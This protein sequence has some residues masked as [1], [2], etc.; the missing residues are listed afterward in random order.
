VKKTIVL[1]VVTGLLVAAAT[2]CAGAIPTTTP[3]T[4]A[5]VDAAVAATGTA[6][7][8]VQATIDAA[9]EAT[10]AVQAGVQAT[11]AAAAE[12]TVVA[13]PTPTPSAEYVTMTEEQ[14]AALID[15]TVV[16]A[17]AST[18]Q[19]S[20]ATAEATVDDV[21]TQ[22]EVDA[23][24]VYAAE[25]EEAIAYAEELIAAYDSL[26][27]ELATETLVLLQAIEEDLTV[28]AE[29]IA[30]ANALLQEIDAALQQ[31][32]TLAEGTLAQ[33][34]TAAQAAGAEA[35]ELQ[36]RNQSV[37]QELQAELENRV[38]TALAVHPDA[39]AGDRQ[40]ALQSALGYLD[41]VRQSLDDARISQ[42]E[43]ADIAQL[44]ANASASLSTQGGPRLQNL[45]G[46]I[47]EI[48]EQIARG[49]IPQAKANLGNL[50]VSLR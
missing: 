1:I 37:L 22:E 12:S 13:A 16:E 42:A 46:S 7:A 14:L 15:E 2:A 34:E 43:L 45:S 11:A 4:Q 23:I 17:T 47:D 36:A 24:E 44:G 19:C 29:S 35:S 50:E 49:Q 26:Y 41:F 31:G 27:G 9:V 38:Q 6:Q 21:V 5:T 25:A 3:D 40:A 20:T 18:Q 33:L 8:G 32:L 39:V 30:A 10:A 28:M 48:T